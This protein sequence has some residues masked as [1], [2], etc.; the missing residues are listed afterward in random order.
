M[1]ESKFKISANNEEN[2]ARLRGAKVAVLGAARS[3]LAVARLLHAH[4]AQV[5]VSDIKPIDPNIEKAMKAMPE[6]EY[7]FGEHSDKVPDSDMICISPGI[8]LTIPILQEAR[9]FNIPVAGELEVACWFNTAPVIA[10]TGSNGKTT[11]TSLTG[12]IFKRHFQR[13]IVGGNIGNPLAD[14]IRKLPNP[15]VCILEVS[16][17]QLETIV[18]FHP[19][20][21]VIMNLSLNHLDRYR[22]FGAYVAAKM[23]ILRNL[24]KNDILIYNADDLLLVEEV[25]KFPG[26]KIPFSLRQK[27][28]YGGYWD[29]NQIQIHLEKN[30]SI[31]PSRL[32]LK[33]PHNRYNM[34]AASLLAVLNDI[35]RKV[36]KSELEN[37][38]GIPHRL[39]EVSTIGGV[40]FVNDSKATTVSS[41]NY[42]LQSFEQPVILIAGG[43]D[44]GGDFS[45][46]NILL[47]KRVRAAVLIGKASQR[48]RESWNSIVP[49][50]DAETLQDAVYTSQYLAERGDVVL[51]SPACSSF[52]MFNDYEDRGNQ[53]KKIVLGLTE[54]ERSKIRV[55]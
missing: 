35:P 9:K 42:A 15:E 26:I 52:D 13:V 45:E 11:T 12:N 10:I 14:E 36:I 50:Y 37:F 27:L 53:F 49:I 6:I 54:Q 39:E 43:I 32:T 1:V 22:D 29:K 28:G 3:G 20:I 48:M 16:S 34:I 33:G 17:F 7:E 44:K 30:Y 23:N 25:L 40:T 21:A 47:K 38:P 31:A 19:H 2:I 5:L 41:L 8:P 4:G 18:N 51:L 46:L 24:H 55:D